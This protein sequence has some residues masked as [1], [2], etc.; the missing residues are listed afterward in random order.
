VRFSGLKASFRIRPRVPRFICRADIAS[1]KLSRF[2][3]LLRAA[4]TFFPVKVMC[5]LA[6]RRKKSF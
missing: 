5:S 3:A 2:R 6:K 1:G 4:H